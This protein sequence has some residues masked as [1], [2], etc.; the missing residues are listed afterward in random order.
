MKK[1][2]ENTYS[3]EQLQYFREEIVN[4]FLKVTA[5]LEE[6][7]TTDK[8]NQAKLAKSIGIS[9]AELSKRLHG[10]GKARLSKDNV[11][12]IVVTFIREEAIASLTHANAIL[13]RMEISTPLTFGLLKEQ[14]A[15]VASNAIF[16]SNGAIPSKDKAAT[17]KVVIKPGLPTNPEISR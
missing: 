3:P 6:E 12:L 1:T 11:L 5:E 13:E 16:R 9:S 8:W 4:H 2:S 10:T 17:P 7:E 14:Y 15:I